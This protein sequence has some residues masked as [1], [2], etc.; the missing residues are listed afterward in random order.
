MTQESGRRARGSCTHARTP[1]PHYYSLTLALLNSYR[2]PPRSCP[3]WR[4]RPEQRRDDDGY[5][6]IPPAWRAVRLRHAPR[7]SLGERQRTDKERQHATAAR[8]RVP[9]RSYLIRVL[10]VVRGACFLQAPPT[11]SLSLHPSLRTPTRSPL[12]SIPHTDSCLSRHSQA[13][14]MQCSMIAFCVEGVC[15][16]CGRAV[17]N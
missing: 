1:T 11:R 2:P 5:G 17:R 12:F 15:G 8:S 10:S 7:P 13:R 9:G 16:A 4:P 14:P 6:R 3:S